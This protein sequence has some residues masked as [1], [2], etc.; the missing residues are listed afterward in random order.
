MVVEELTIALPEEGSG[1]RFHLKGRALSAAVGGPG[2]L[3]HF[4]ESMKSSPFFANVELVS[5]EMR[6][7]AAGSTSVEVEGALK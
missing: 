2:G 5:S 4:L 7:S 1:W 3:S 6:T